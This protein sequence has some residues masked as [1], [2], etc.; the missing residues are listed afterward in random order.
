MLR[1]ERF[2]PVE[3]EPDLDVHRLLRPER[4][5]IVKDGDA[6]G[7][8]NKRVL[9]L[10]R[11][12]L[13]ELYDGPSIGRVIPRRQRIG[14]AQKATGDQQKCQSGAGGS[15]WFHKMEDDARNRE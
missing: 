9:A 8:R 4:A 10:G 2:R 7:G 11:D 3:G 15:V 12:A 6:F 14:G 13:D 1:C 5:V